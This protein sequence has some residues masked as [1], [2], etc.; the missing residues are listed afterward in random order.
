[1]H[2]CIQNEFSDPP[3]VFLENPWI[4]SYEGETV[5]LVCRVYSNPVA[6]VGK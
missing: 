6:K 3:E 5:T 4:H 2:S 1:M